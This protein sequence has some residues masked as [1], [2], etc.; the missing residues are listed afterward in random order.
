M[1]GKAGWDIPF[2][3]SLS[4]TARSEAIRDEVEE[5]VKAALVAL[6]SRPGAAPFTPTSVILCGG[7]CSR[8]HGAAAEREKEEENGTVDSRK[9]EE[10]S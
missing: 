7:C 3:E 10:G 8:A 6:R 9:K 2:W 4:S 5:D 1:V